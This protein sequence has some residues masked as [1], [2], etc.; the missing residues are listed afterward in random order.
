VSA[1]DKLLACFPQAQYLNP[2]NR[3]LVEAAADEILNE[4]AH[5]LAEK[6]REF[7]GPESYP[8]E[9]GRPI[10]HYVKGWRDAADFINPEVKG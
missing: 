6:V 1:R 7:I 4:H 9:S 10:L 3:A 2:E 5:E 8:H